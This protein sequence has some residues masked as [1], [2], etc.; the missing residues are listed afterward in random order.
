MTVP[1]PARRF[2]PPARR[3]PGA[4]GVLVELL[5]AGGA[6]ALAPPAFER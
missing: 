6:S 2:S 5:V 1:S 4:Q 3:L